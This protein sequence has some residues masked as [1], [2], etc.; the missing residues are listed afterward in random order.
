MSRTKPLAP[1]AML[2]NPTIHAVAAPRGD[3]DFR[4][5][6]RRAMTVATTN[7]NEALVVENDFIFSFLLCHGI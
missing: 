4:F 6:P 3:R 1:Q 7:P 2:K 5:I